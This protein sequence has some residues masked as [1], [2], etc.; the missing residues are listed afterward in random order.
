MPIL[1]LMKKTILKILLVIIGIIILALFLLPGII[2]RYA[3]TNSKELIGRQIDIEKL[4]YNYFT[5]TV[6]VYDFRMF[7]NDESDN[8]LSFDTLIIDLEPLKLFEDKI[9]IEQFF[10]EGLN[11]NV[12]M[13]DSVFNFDDLIDFHAS[14]EDSVAQN[15]NKD[16]F[17][18]SISNIDIE[19]SDFY[20]DNQNITHKT[21]IKDLSFIVPF[22][23]W[24][25][26]EKS[27]ADIKFKLPR[28]GYFEVK[29]NLNPID[30]E[31]DAAL[32]ISDLYLDPFYKYVAQHAEINSFNGLVNS[33][34]YIEG[35]T[36]EAVKSIVSG[37]IS[38]AD[39]VMTDT[40]SK[41]F[42]SANKMDVAIKNID[43]YH[44]SYI[45]DSIR[46]NKAYTFFQ[47]DSMSN[48]FVRIFKLDSPTIATED[49]PVNEQIVDSGETTETETQSDLYYAINHLKMDHGVLDYS[50]KL[51]GNPFNYHLSEIKLN[52]DSVFSD[53]DWV[54]IH[55]DMILNNRG[56][57]NAEIGFNPLSLNDADVDI[58]IE[59]FL[60]SDLN[61][62]TKHYTGHNIIKG[63]MYYYSYSKI[64]NGVIVSENK[65]LIKN[66]SLNTTKGG[67][68]SLPLKFA[69]FLLKDKNGDVNLDIPVRG[70]LNDPTVRIG[71][72]V[73]NTFKNLIVKTVASP[74]NFLANLVDGD[75]KEMETISFSY[76]DSIPTQKHYTQLDKV[77]ELE[78]KKP[79]LKIEMTYFVDRELQKEA[80]AK[81]E[82]GKEY[83]RD[84]KIDYLKDE[85]GFEIYLQNK[86]GTDSII[87]A[88]LIMAF[89]GNE[90]LDELIFKQNDHLISVITDYIKSSQTSSLIQIK[91]AKRDAI[92]NIGATPILK[93]DYGMQED[94]NK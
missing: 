41:V 38:I 5:S 68:Y 64:A 7:E 77:L 20:F 94:D 18:F 40:K 81:Q 70:D 78:E 87:S 30:G 93:I 19:K 59:D 51:T 24:D 29:L 11:V 53:T 72:I 54:K 45:I 4:K 33:S 16:S 47:L 62:Y 73:W 21:S 75:P 27:N 9:E 35:N 44:N 17:K 80:L 34:I 48:N 32:K 56:T 82:V 69:I 88:Q 2:K 50:D 66:V 86:I 63:D 61:I 71:K 15:T 76:L 91:V 65:L 58:V 31:F 39:F 90:K 79:G 10:L 52:F 13:R 57:L 60:L 43:F 46:I 92:K 8:F 26:E 49:E 3:I 89:V 36:N 25:Q 37:Q 1:H 22:I 67:L 55:S 74:I 83:F 42:L 12:V 23:G 14:E 28:G 85:K 84:T 6:K